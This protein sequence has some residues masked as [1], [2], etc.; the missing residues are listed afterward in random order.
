MMKLNNRLYVSQNTTIRELLEVIPKYTVI[1]RIAQTP[2]D[3]QLRRVRLDV[4]LP[5]RK[6][7][8][9]RAR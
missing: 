2:K 8:S 4:S 7:V 1:E 6:I 3:R 9:K 5:L